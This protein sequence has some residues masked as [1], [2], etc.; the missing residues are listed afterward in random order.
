M[1]DVVDRTDLSEHLLSSRI[2]SH[3]E[4]GPKSS[5]A[6]RDHPRRHWDG[7]R[8]AWSNSKL[9]FISQLVPDFA[10]VGHTPLRVAWRQ[11]GGDEKSK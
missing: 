1:V 9:E 3:S 5:H 4:A 6:A 7:I 8:R 11:I 10:G 2:L